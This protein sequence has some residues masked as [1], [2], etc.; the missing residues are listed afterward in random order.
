M[1]III[2]FS[3]SLTIR[4]FVLKFVK[5]HGF[6]KKLKFVNIRSRSDTRDFIRSKKRNRLTEIWF[7]FIQ[8]CDFSI[9]FLPSTTQCRQFPEDA[10]DA[11]VSECT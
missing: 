1:V 8:T 10:K 2:D 6:K 5:V 7:M 11:S 3:H 4:D 9:R